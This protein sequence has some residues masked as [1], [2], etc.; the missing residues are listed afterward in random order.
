MEVLRN[1][2]GYRRSMY[3]ER[4]KLYYSK[5]FSV[6]IING[7]E[8]LHT[9]FSFPSPEFSAEIYDRL[10]K[11][12]NVLN[13]RRTDN[14]CVV[15]L[16]AGTDLKMNDSNTIFYGYFVPYGNDIS[17][18]TLPIDDIIKYTILTFHAL[19][20]LESCNIIHHDIRWSNILTF[21]D[22]VYI[23]DLDE[24]YYVPELNTCPSVDEI[25]VSKE[26]H[27]PYSFKN[28]HGFEVHVW[29]IGHLLHTASFNNEL[30]KLAQ[31]LKDECLNI[32]LITVLNKLQSVK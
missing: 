15:Q 25:F 1:S 29:S 23:I 4:K 30:Y 20:F 24:A 27:C 21:E 13:E 18:K 2:V 19:I 16:L 7:V 17:E 11:V 3:W 6:Q 10:Y 9:L 32:P 5:K 26:E 12:L 31:E 14:N 8:T 28:N 22:R